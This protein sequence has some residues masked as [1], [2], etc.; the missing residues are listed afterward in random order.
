[1]KPYNT[2]IY[3]WKDE[4]LNIPW[5]KENSPSTWSDK[6]KLSILES[7]LEGRAEND[8]DSEVEILLIPCLER[9]QYSE[10]EWDNLYMS[11]W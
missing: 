3:K 1:M 5:Y 6:M 7:Y 8:R 4:F 10:Q 9:N 2:I 11:E